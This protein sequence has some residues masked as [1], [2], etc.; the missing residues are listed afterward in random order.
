MELLVGLLILGAMLAAAG[1]KPIAGDSTPPG[2]PA[3]E[4]P[5]LFRPVGGGHE[6]RVRHTPTCWT[7][8]RSKNDGSHGH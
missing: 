3:A 1:S 5:D 7:C 2:R 4:A 6:R 8:G